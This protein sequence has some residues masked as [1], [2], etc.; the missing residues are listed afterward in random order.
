[1]PRKLD[2]GLAATYSKSSDLMTS[3]MK[4]PPGLSVVNISTVEGGS[5]SRGGVGAMAVAGPCCAAAFV[6]PGTSAAA[7]AAAPVTAALLR[8]PRR[9]T[10]SVLDIGRSLHLPPPD[11]AQACVLTSRRSEERRVGKECTHR[12]S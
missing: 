2:P 10:E 8:K 11:N 5:I 7:P 9:S 6:A 4:S 3:T 1:M 12:R